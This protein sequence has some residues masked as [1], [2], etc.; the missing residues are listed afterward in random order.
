A[1]F[2]MKVDSDGFTHIADDGVIRSW[3]ANGTVI[4]AVRLTNSQLLEQISNVPAHL[5]PFVPHLKKVYAHVDGHDVPE[6]QL[7]HPTR[8]NTPTEFGGPTVLQAAQSLN[9]A[10]VLRRQSQ[11][12]RWCIGRICTR[13]SACQYLGCLVCHDFDVILLSRKVCAGP[14]IPPSRGSGG[15]ELRGSA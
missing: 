10:D 9:P 14:I 3:A 8:I 1:M 12:P 5:K 4:D 11:D 13:S 6:S 2:T 15:G 7:Y